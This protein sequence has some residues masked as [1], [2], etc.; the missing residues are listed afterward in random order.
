MEIEQACAG[1]EESKHGIIVF[2][3]PEKRKEA[4]FDET[5]AFFRIKSNDIWL[6]RYMP[7]F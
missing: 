4:M 5:S 2:K 1:Q 7:P 6:Q 3:S